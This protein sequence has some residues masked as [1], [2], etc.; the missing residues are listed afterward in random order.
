MR[1]VIGGRTRLETALGTFRVAVHTSEDTPEHCVSISQGDLSAPGVVVRLHS[2]CLFGEAFLAS[3]CDCGAQL[4]TALAEID[5]R[6]RGVVVYL[7]Q[8]GR[9]AG[10]DLKCRAMEQQH[11]AGLN[12]YESYELLGLPRDLRQYNLA[13]VALR[14]LGVSGQVTALFNNPQKHEALERFGYTIVEHLVV[15]YEVSIRAYDY[16]QMKRDV[17]AHALDFSKISF[18]R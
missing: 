9:G 11:V 5:R 18:V 15:P 12:S 13:G 10:L 17:G 7:Y 8:E 3:D 2:S 16:L 4:S 14:D 1:F 6:G